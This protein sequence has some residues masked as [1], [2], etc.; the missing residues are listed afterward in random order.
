MHHTLR[1]TKKVQRQRLCVDTAGTVYLNAAC[2]PRIVKTNQGLRRNFSL[3]TL[4]DQQVT[5]VKLVWLDETFTIVTDPSERVATSETLYT[6]SAN[7]LTAP[8]HYTPSVF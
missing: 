2:V 5:E 3:V 7:D 1:H 8:A 6:K 4:Q